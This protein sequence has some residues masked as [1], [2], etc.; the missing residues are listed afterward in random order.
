MDS[1]LKILILEDN[2]IDADL[3]HRELKKSGLIFTHEVVQ[4]RD[5]FELSIENFKPDL[6]LSDFSL[7]SFDGLSAF[8]IKQEK[9]PGIPFM[10]ISGTIGDENA[11]ELIKNGVTDYVLK[12]KLFSLMPKIH[13]A[14]NE[15]REKQKKEE[16]EHKMKM[17]NEKLFEI[18]FLQSHQV[19]RP[20]ASIQGL[21]GLFNFKAPDDPINSE[22][23]SRLQI[24]TLEFDEIIRSIVQKTYEIKNIK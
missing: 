19:R 10:I 6:I 17:Q 24:A 11:V 15:I 12:D 3:I 1:T 9:I 5:E 7:P 16:I 22:V 21:I 2:P 23:L 18:A 14:L 13:R 8:K 20:V 4:T